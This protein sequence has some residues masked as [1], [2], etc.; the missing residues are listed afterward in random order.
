MNHIDGFPRAYYYLAKILRGIKMNIRSIPLLLV[1]CAV[2]A[3]SAPAQQTNENQIIQAAD[4]AARTVTKLRGLE[5]KSPIQ[6]GVKSREEI[7]GFLN[8][9][10]QEEYLPERIEQE[11]VLFKKLGFLSESIDYR[12]LL[13]NLLSEQIEGFYDPETRMLFL[14]SWLPAESQDTVMV[15]EITH[16]LQDQHFDL[17]AILRADR[18]TGDDDRSLAHSALF[19]GDGSVV[20]LQYTISW[21]NRHFSDLPDLASI[22]QMS[23]EVAQSQSET[24]KASPKFMKEN[25]V[26]PYS[27][28]SAFI[29]QIWKQNPSWDA[30]NKIY[31]DLP[32]STEQI[33]HPEKYYGTRDNPK[34]VDAGALAA[35][36]G[37]DWKITYKNVFGEF[38][39]GQ[40]LNLHMTEERAKRAAMGWGGDQVILLKNSAGKTAAWIET[41]WDTKEDAEKFFAAMDEWFRLH[42]PNDSRKNVTANGFSL[43]RNGEV[44]SLRKNGAGVRIIIG[45]PEADNK[46]LENL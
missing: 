28:G 13:V 8:K 44:G 9:K 46:K 19:E 22:Y 36:L 4:E 15:H 41:E 40:L 11:G 18:A 33:M 1:L 35:R 37:T 34:P 16:A 30:I 12:Q 32:A 2:I 25:L 43:T 38:M 27:Y 31:A 45:I 10:L 3:S 26:F 17:Q 6:K 23:M 5:Q 39:L 21:S 7:T 20:A 24:L 29:Q 14:A 42:Y